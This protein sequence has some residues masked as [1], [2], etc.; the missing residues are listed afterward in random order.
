MGLL[1]AYDIVS[2]LSQGASVA[3]LTVEGATVL[4]CLLIASY[5][6]LA[7]IR[8][9]KDVRQANQNLRHNLAESLGSAAKWKSEAE[10]L[11]TGLGKVI[12]RQFS[13]WRLT[14]VEK[15]IALFLLKGLSHKE[16]AFIRNVSDATVRQQSRSIYKKAGV[17]GR[18]GLAAFFLEDLALPV[19]SDRVI[20]S[21]NTSVG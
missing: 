14:P 18:H 4:C 16:V 5:L 6:I 11:L 8:D 13:D 12:D 10:S 3:H 7:M 17:T 9:A 21:S 19:G 1:A 15:D 20:A 2:D